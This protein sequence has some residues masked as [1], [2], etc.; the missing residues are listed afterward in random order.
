MG[1]VKGFFSRIPILG[2][3]VVAIVSLLSGEPPAQAAFK[4]I[5]AA[6]GGALGTFIPIPILGTL[7]GEAIGSFVG[8]L[9][10]YGIIEGDWKKAGKVF[11]Q[12]L[13][14]ILSAGGRYLS[15]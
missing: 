14:A 8:D 5:G 4:G 1:A 13:K 3:L 11:G 6:L 2:P 15:T 10:Y 9:L 12:T 7:L